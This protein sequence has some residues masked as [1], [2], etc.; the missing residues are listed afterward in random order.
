MC[1]LARRR[2]S[3]WNLVEKVSEAIL[4]ILKFGLL[5]L[6]YLF[7]FMMVKLLVTSV[8]STVDGGSAGTRAL[9]IGENRGGSP[10]TLWVVSSPGRHPQSLP[11]TPE[12]TVGRSQKCDLPLPEDTFLSQY[13]ARFSLRDG[14]CFVEDLGSTNGT[15][16]NGKRI[17]GPTEVERG[18]RVVAGKT[19]LELRK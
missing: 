17:E 7:V 14:A 5:G 18:D 3:T 1:R 8:R 4:A 12:L 16:L 10:A 2:V 15:R 11:L 19:V 13:H 6:L 9:K